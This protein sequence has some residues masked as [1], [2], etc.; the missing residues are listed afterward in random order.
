MEDIDDYIRRIG[1]IFLFGSMAIILIT[2][3]IHDVIKHYK[4]Y[5][6]AL[7]NLF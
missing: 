4:E 2:E 1:G 3:T 7:S 5:I 6:S